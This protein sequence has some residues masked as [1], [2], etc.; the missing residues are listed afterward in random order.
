[1]AYAEECGASSSTS[2]SSCTIC[3]AAAAAAAV[4]DYSFILVH[5]LADARHAAWVGL[6][7]FVVLCCAEESSI[8]GVCVTLQSR[9]WVCLHVS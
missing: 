2:C 7:N 8:C 4:D 5:S 3:A 6:L 9:V 1:M